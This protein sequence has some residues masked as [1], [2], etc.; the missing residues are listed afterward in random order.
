MKRRPYALR[1]AGEFTRF[2]HERRA[3][4][5][6][7]LVAILALAALFVVGGEVITPLIYTIF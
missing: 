1:L 5:L 3:Y 6:I 2:A 7:P 4:W